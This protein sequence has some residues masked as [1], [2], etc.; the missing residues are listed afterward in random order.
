L[1][2]DYNSSW[3]VDYH[4]SQ[5]QRIDARTDFSKKVLYLELKQRLPELLLMRADKMSMAEG[6]EARIPFLDYQLVEFMFNVP[7]R[8]KFKGQQ[9]KYLLKKVAEKYLPK[10]IIYRK[11]IGF[12]APTVR[13]FEKGKYFPAYYSKVVGKIALVINEAEK[14][15]DKY[16]PSKECFAVQ[17]WTLQNFASVK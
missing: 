8:L 5:L 1:G 11:K 14:I 3:I 4:L 16:K 9:T 12:S 7:G 17:K 2:Q 6:V 10:D 13:W 15:E